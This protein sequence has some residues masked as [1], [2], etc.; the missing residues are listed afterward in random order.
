MPKAPWSEAFWAEGR[1]TERHSWRPSVSV[2]LASFISASASGRFQSLPLQNGLQSKFLRVRRRP[3]LPG[4]N[5]NIQ[6][7]NATYHVQTEDAGGSHGQIVT[8]LFLGGNVVATKRCSYQDVAGLPDADEQILTRMQEQHKQ[9]MRELIRGHFD[10]IETGP[11]H[12]LSGPAPLNHAMSNEQKSTDGSED[13][14][15]DL[16]G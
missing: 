7:R 8:N 6:H 9:M 11:V 10:Q 13:S 2:W 1:G 4:F 12:H 16:R 14:D 3:M 15:G 5:H